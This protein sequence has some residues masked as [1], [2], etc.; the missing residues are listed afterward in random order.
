MVIASIFCTEYI[1]KM[2]L[3]SVMAI[4][5]IM[6]PTSRVYLGLSSYNEVIYGS[7]IGVALAFVGHFRIKPIVKSLP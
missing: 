7:L 6:L 5:I 2:A 1:V 4:F 3:T